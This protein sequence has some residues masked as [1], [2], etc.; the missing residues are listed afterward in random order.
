MRTLETVYICG[1]F[2]GLHQLMIKI[3]DSQGFVESKPSTPGEHP[4]INL[5]FVGLFSLLAG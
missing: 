3:I 4:L 1:T 5:V 2:N